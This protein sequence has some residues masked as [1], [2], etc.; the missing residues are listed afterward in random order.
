MLVYEKSAR[1][2]EREALCS[3]LRASRTFLAWRHVEE[4]RKPRDGELEGLKGKSVPRMPIVEEA[5]EP[6]DEK[7]A[8]AAKLKRLKELCFG[9]VSV[10]DL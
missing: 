4:V 10:R 6:P 1:K 9:T 5:S 8:F 7:Y 2:Y 3:T